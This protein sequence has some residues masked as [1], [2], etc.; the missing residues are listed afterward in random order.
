MS[1]AVPS[2]SSEGAA[3]GPSAGASAALSSRAEHRRGVRYGLALACMVLGVYLVM[4][5]NPGPLLYDAAPLF[6]VQTVLQLAIAVLVLFLGLAVAPTSVARAA[7]SAVLVAGLIIVA[8]LLFYFRLT[9]AL[10][11]PVVMLGSLITPGY[12]ALGGALLGWLI[13]RRRHPLTYLLVLGALLPGLVRHALV[14]AGAG[15]GMIWFS[16]LLITLVVGVG[17]AWIAAG[18]SWMLGRRATSPREPMRTVEPMSTV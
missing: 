8:S 14:L 7:I 5:W 6:R 11:L 4:Q 13:V 18:V 3:P 16:D 12:A 2:F 9:G 10:M 1:S 15:A 17:G